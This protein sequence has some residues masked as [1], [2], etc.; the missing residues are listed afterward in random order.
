MAAL[1]NV[2]SALAGQ[3]PNVILVVTDDQGYGDIAAHGNPIIRTPNLDRLH[4]ESVRLTDF[5]VDPTCAPTRSALMS[6]KFAHRAR[7]W[8]TIQ[9]G[10][11]LREGEV[12]MADVFKHNGYD[13]AMFGKWHLGANYPYR[14]MDRGFDEWLGLGDGGTGTS[15]DWFWNDR[16]NDTYW[17]NGEREYRAGY[18]T[19]VFFSAALD[20]VKHRSSDKPFFIYLPTYDPHAPYTYF[21]PGFGKSGD[22]YRAKGLN[23]ELAAFYTE[24]ERVDWNLGRLRQALADAG[25]ADNTILIF[26]TDNGSP[27]GEESFNAGMSGKKGSVTEGGHRVPCF[28][29]WPA[30]KLGEPRDVLAL[31]AHIDLLPTLTELCSMDLPKPIDFDGQS[32]VP[33]LRGVAVDWPD[34]TLVVER[35]RELKHNL[36]FNAIMTQ[37]WRLVSHNKLY[38][39]RK[40]PGEKTDISKQHPEVVQRLLKEFERYWVRVIPDDR[41]FPIPIAGTPHDK[42]LLLSFSDLRGGEAFS[43]G[44]AA[45][46][47]AVTGDYHLEAAESGIYEFE[48]CRWPREADAAISGVPVVTKKADGWSPEGPITALLYSGKFVSMPIAAVSL[49]VGDFSEKRT[50]TASDRSV[51]FDVALPKGRTVVNAAF[52]DQAGTSLTKAYYVYVRKKQ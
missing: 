41:G 35:Q 43:H 44:Q 19:D 31:T 14:P 48:V 50:V 28:I 42:E 33:L 51:V 18:N 2:G 45:A 4:D 27:H 22:Y 26:M 37:Q 5:H 21:E 30:G 40:D 20:F 9:G 29:D 17:H 34:R 25:V 47:K 7:V 38:D 24:I 46:G 6:G 3:R 39:I 12:T 10:N 8:H 16:M 13:T 23:R 32:L 11:Y 49:Q 52:Y 15:D 1:L 36:T